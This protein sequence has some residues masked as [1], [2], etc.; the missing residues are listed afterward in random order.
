ME[1]VFYEKFFYSKSLALFDEERPQVKNKTF[2]VRVGNYTLTP[3]RPQIL[4]I[5]L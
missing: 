1:I 5:R 3:Y 2:F 4:T